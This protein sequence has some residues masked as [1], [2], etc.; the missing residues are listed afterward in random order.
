LINF[1]DSFTIECV[2][3]LGSPPL[4][5]VHQIGG[6]MFAFVCLCL[7]SSQIPTSL[8]TIF[9]SQWFSRVYVWFRTKIWDFLF[10]R[11]SCLPWWGGI[12]K[13]NEM[14]KIW[15]SMG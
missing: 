9:C 8:L 10:N 12:E 11:K 4:Q 15:I 13:G 2:L 14:K 5:L 3:Y 1:T 6:F 7:L